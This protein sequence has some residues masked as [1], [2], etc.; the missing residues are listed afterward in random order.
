MDDLAKIVQ[1]RMSEV[2]WICAN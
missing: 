2:V 1:I